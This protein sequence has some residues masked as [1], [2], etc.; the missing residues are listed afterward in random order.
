M[1]K[2]TRKTLHYF[3]PFI[4]EAKFYKC[5]MKIQPKNYIKKFECNDISIVVLHFY[6]DTL[7]KKCMLTLLA[8]AAVDNRNLVVAGIL[9]AD[10]LAVDNTAD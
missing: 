6:T 10:I 1:Y 2:N 3:P 9:V 5:E 4:N 7:M 8:A